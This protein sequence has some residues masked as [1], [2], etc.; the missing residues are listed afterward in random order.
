MTT[1][2][3]SPVQSGARQCEKKDF[4]PARLISS[5]QLDSAKKT[6]PVSEQDLV[7]EQGCSRVQVVPIPTWSSCSALGVRLFSGLL[8]RS[9]QLGEAGRRRFVIDVCMASGPPWWQVRNGFGYRSRQPVRRPAGQARDAASG[10]DPP[11]CGSAWFQ[12]ILRC[13]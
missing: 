4:L 8:A 5:A 1:A 2:L 6:S 11:P 10:G 9:V 7:R 3:H 13:L 12:L